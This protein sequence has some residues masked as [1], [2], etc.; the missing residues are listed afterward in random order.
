MPTIAKV[1]QEL[2]MLCYQPMFI[3]TDVHS[4]VLIKAAQI[5]AHVRVNKVKP[6]EWKALGQLG[7]Q[8]AVLSLME[9]IIDDCKKK[10]K[11]FAPLNRRKLNSTKAVKALLSAPKSK[12]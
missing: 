7:Q 12:P 1:I 11:I 6:S 2:N 8:C 10:Q 4:K 5:Q 3:D 9:K